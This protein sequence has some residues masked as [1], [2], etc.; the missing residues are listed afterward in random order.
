MVAAVVYRGNSVDD[1]VW[2]VSGAATDVLIENNTMTNSLQ[3]STT[4]HG[5]G[6]CPTACCQGFRVRN[7]KQPDGATNVTTVFRVTLRNNVGMAAGTR[8]A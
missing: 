7:G 4:G 6:Y 3:C 1:G 8:A 5:G 2:A